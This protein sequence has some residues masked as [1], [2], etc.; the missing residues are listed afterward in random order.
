MKPREVIS[1]RMGRAIR[2]FE[3][4]TQRIE[5][6]N[7]TTRLPRNSSSTSFPAGLSLCTY[8]R[9]SIPKGLAKYA[10]WLPPIG[11]LR[12]LLLEILF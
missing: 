8:V 6:M 11:N 7:G 1:Q 5:M 2:I 4:W 3:P 12:D 10:F 9:D